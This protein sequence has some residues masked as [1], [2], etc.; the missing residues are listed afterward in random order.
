MKNFSYVKLDLDRIEDNDSYQV[1]LEN[2]TCTLNANFLSKETNSTGNF[3]LIA[4]EG[5]RTFGGVPRKLGFVACGIVFC[6]DHKSSDLST[7]GKHP[8]KGSLINFFAF[9]EISHY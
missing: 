6:F 2:Y 8:A 5:Q 9:I 1:A 4:Q 3:A 7:C